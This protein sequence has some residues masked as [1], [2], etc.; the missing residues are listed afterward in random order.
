M[1]EEK[2]EKEIKI[3]AERKRALLAIKPQEESLNNQIK[4]NNRLKIS[5]TWRTYERG[6][7]KYW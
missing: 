6:G 5:G 7:W 2:Q 4:V 1:E 3:E